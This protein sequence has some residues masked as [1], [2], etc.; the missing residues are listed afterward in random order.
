MTLQILSQIMNRINTFYTKILLISI[1]YYFWW[2]FTKCCWN[3]SE[4]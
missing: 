2:S 4:V 3:R 1:I